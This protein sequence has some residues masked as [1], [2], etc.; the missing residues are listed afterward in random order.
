MGE[1][2][3]SNEVY[4]ALQRQLYQ[5]ARLLSSEQYDDWLAM[6]S[7]DI[8]YAMEMP[9]AALEKIKGIEYRTKHRYLMTT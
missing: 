4:I 8:H 7:E 9:S 2:Q 3:A 5:E 6:V 1:Q